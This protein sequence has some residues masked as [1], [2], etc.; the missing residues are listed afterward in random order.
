LARILLSFGSSKRKLESAKKDIK[1]S[2]AEKLKANKF[3]KFDFRDKGMD[4]GSILNK[5]RAM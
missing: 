4:E 2:V 1:Q 3:K 5:L